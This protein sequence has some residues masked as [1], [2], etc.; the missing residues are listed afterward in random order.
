MISGILFLVG[1]TLFGLVYIVFLVKFATTRTYSTGLL[2]AVVGAI[3]LVVIYCVAIAIFT[4][5]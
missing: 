1:L 4:N 3:L 5:L 2:I